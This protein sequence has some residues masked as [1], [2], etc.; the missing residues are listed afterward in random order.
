[1][2]PNRLYPTTS[3]Q[4]IV[5]ARNC[6]DDANTNADTKGFHTK[7]QYVPLPLVGGDKIKYPN[8]YG[9]YW[10]NE[11]PVVNQVLHCLP[12]SQDLSHALSDT[13]V[14][15]GLYTPDRFFYFC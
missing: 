4:D 10:R 5:Q 11:G 13:H 14:F 2:Y 7:K 15:M 12:F 3:S 6:D 1:M 9:N 8:I